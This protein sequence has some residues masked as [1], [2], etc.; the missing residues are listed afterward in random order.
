MKKVLLCLA[1]LGATFLISDEIRVSSEQSDYDGEYLQL[2]GDVFVEH[3]FGSLSADRARA[4][5]KQGKADRQ[6]I[7]EDNV[8]ITMSDGGSLECGKATLDGRTLLGVFRSNDRQKKVT[9]RGYTQDNA[10]QLVPLEVSSAW[11]QVQLARIGD[12]ATTIVESIEAQG[13]VIIKCGTDIRAVADEAIYQ[14]AG[15]LSSDTDFPGKIVLKPWFGK[16][17]K[18]THSGR[19]RIVADK[20]QIDTV[21]HQL[22][23]ENASGQFLL[24]KDD[25]P[26][27]R[28]IFKAKEICW[29]ERDE[30]LVLTGDVEIKEREMGKVS[31]DHQMI[32]KF[33]RANGQR[34]L[35]YLESPARTTISYNNPEGLGKHRAYCPG[36]VLI[37]HCEKVAH[38]KGQG[39]EQLHYLDHMGELY[40]NRA[41][42]FYRQHEDEPQ[43]E[44]LQLNGTVRIRNTA[45]LDPNSNEPV[46]QYALADE[47]VFIADEHRLRMTSSGDRRVLFFDKFRN[48]RM[49]AP[50][51]EIRRDGE[52]Q[53][54][55]FQGIGDVRFTFAQQEMDEMES[56]FRFNT[57]NIAEDKLINSG[58]H[59]R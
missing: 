34:E 39:T 18:V 47:A 58:R 32:A 31:T 14:H 23:F 30:R 55:T 43:L 10:G 59:E 6:V 54:K 11:M 16:H 15:Y 21:T 25:V 17:C 36:R 7:L 5:Y 53:K 41:T 42:L 24:M 19:D 20:I 48:V 50:G 8:R 51:I 40:A 57:Q 52:N 46:L 33:K 1:L 37:D 13:K 28:V 35:A 26:T 4:P 38:L 56:V 22:S 12:A 9:Y 29:H 27:D 3:A 45:P 44:R 49:S 2:S